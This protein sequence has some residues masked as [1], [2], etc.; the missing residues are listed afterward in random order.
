MDYRQRFGLAHDVFPQHAQGESFFETAAYRRL[1]R[2]FA[3]LAQQPG[4]G[5]LAGEV[6]VGKTAAIRNLAAGLPRPDYRV[7]YLCEAPAGPTEL[8][9]RLAA[10]LGVRAPHRRV[11]L[12]RDLKTHLLQLVDEHRVQPLV[13]LDDAHR[14]PESVLSD[15]SSLVNDAMDT[16]NLVALWLVGHPDLLAVLR[17]KH[18]AA[19]ASRLAVRLQLAPLSGRDEFQAFLAHG[20]GAAGAKSKLISDAAA[21]LLFRVSHGLPRQAGR[22]LRQAL[23]RAHE[24]ERSMVDDLILEAVLDEESL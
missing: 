22:L 12:R 13:I 3:M 19:L 4:I 17:M 10:E 1:K 9:R 5:V 11:D 6:G 20:L 18:H 15:L 2:R 14:L 7:L 24:E 23:V 21:E 8:Y 16:R